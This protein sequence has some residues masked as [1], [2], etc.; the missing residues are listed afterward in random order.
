MESTD[1]WVF[2]CTKLNTTRGTVIFSKLKHTHVSPSFDPRKKNVDDNKKNHLAHQSAT[3]LPE[4]SQKNN[5]IE[6]LPGD[7]YQGWNSNKLK[8]N[9]FMSQLY[10]V[11]LVSEMIG[12][13]APL[14]TVILPGRSENLSRYLL[15]LKTILF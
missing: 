8:S 12:C 1:P 7:F 4:I 5:R 15:K 11:L 2:I 14:Q 6:Y 3:N 10:I 9:C 13:K